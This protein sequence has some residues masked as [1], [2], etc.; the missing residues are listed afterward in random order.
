MILCVLDVRTDSSLFLVILMLESRAVSVLEGSID[1][2]KEF[3]TFENKAAS[4]TAAF[5]PSEKMP[6]WGA[7]APQTTRGSPEVGGTGGIRT[8]PG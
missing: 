7:P 2:G 3:V 8:H 1:S 4:V 5:S 6:L